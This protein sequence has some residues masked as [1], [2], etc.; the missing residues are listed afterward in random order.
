MIEFLQGIVFG[1]VGDMVLGFIA[2]IIANK[3]WDFIVKTKAVFNRDLDKIEQKYPNVG[4]AIHEGITEA[5]KVIKREDVEK[6]FMFVANYTKQSIKGK[7]DDLIID[8]LVR[9]YFEKRGL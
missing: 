8:L 4:L 2:A 5:K 6:M 9:K 1:Q 3:A 7:L